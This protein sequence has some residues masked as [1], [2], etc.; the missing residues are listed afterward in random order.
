MKFKKATNSSNSKSK[1]FPQPRT[2][3]FKPAY[4]MTKK[5]M[6]STELTIADSYPHE[7]NMKIGKFEVLR[8]VENRYEKKLAAA[9]ISGH[10]SSSSSI[11]PKKR[12]INNLPNPIPSPFHNGIADDSTTMIGQDSLNH[13]SAADPTEEDSMNM[14]AE[15]LLSLSTAGPAPPEDLTILIEQVSRGK[16]IA[17]PEAKLVIQKELYKTDLD[18]G[19]GRL[20]IPF[21]QIKSV[22][23]TKEKED[24][25]R[26]R[27]MNNRKNH[28]EVMIMAPGVAPVAVKLS[29]WVTEK[30]NGGKKSRSYVIN[31]KWN[32]FV[33]NNNNLEVGMVVQLW[34]FQLEEELCF[35]LL[36]VVP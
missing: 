21:S 23:L 12:K 25:L 2:C 32:D 3:E 22:F 17:T 35:A 19:H 15:I 9:Q 18:K 13:G 27:A 24:F 5:V 30:S 8:L 4:L 36:P 29:E 33:K 28:L 6:A 34:C 26:G 14:I 7:L 20:S 11:R 1:S 10:S 31:G 16:G